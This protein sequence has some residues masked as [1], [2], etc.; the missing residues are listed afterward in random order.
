MEDLVNELLEVALD[1]VT[2]PLDVVLEGD[3]HEGH[4]QDEAD[5]AGD[6]AYAE[7][8][9]AAEDGLE[10]EEEEVAAVE[11]RDGQEVDEAE[12][13]GDHRHRPDEVAD[14]LLALLAHHVVH[15]DR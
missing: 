13:D 1:D 11:H 14:A 8:E 10:E 7:G 4:E 6:L 9:R 12:V 15:G 2:A 3:A 5:Q